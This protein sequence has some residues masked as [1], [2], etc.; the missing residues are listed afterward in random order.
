MISDHCRDDNHIVCSPSTYQPCACACHTIGTP[1]WHRRCA[2]YAY[3]AL[4]KCPPRSSTRRYW[5]RTIREH[6]K[7]MEQYAKTH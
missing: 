2:Q 5:L 1:D 7:A 4:A 6:E 3:Q